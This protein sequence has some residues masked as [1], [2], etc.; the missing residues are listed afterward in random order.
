MSHRT[1]TGWKLTDRLTHPFWTLFSWYQQRQL[2]KT[3]GGGDVEKGAR[4]FRLAF[5][6]LEFRELDEELARR[7]G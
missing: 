7:D 3:I 4:L 6:E 2:F 1:A 5:I